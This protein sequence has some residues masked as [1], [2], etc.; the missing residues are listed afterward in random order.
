MRTGLSL[1]QTGTRPGTW[2]T[3][4]TTVR[5]WEGRW[6]TSCSLVRNAVRKPKPFDSV[7]S[8]F[9]SMRRYLDFHTYSLCD[10]GAGWIFCIFLGLALLPQRSD[11]PRPFPLGPQRTFCS[12]KHT[13]PQKSGPQIGSASQPCNDAWCLC[14][15]PSL[16]PAQRE[17]YHSRECQNSTWIHSVNIRVPWGRTQFSVTWAQ[18]SFT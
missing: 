2:G 13:E 4:R 17:H 14:M 7:P 12:P 8:G 9:C 11:L 18:S 10:G 16:L 15:L 5:R 3:P 6:G 1:A